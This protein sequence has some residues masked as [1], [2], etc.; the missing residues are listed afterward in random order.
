MTPTLS[1]V[2][3][4][5]P[6]PDFAAVR[7]WAWMEAFRSR[8]AD[9]FSPQTL[10]AF[11]AQWDDRAS[12]EQRWAVYRN[13]ELG[14]LVTLQPLSPCVLGSH[15]V[16]KRSFWGSDTTTEALHQVYSLAFEIPTINKI[17]G[18]VFHDNA[19][20]IGLCK[21]LGFTIEGRLRNHTMRGGQPVDMIALGLTRE[22]FT[23]LGQPSQ[24]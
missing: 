8:V 3:V 14:G 7:V 24:D 5:T 13:D 21:S 9:D 15:C 23:C 1:A 11:M 20:I 18:V 12:S 19:Q 10:D 4:E 2:R 6:F 22:D 17:F 16:F